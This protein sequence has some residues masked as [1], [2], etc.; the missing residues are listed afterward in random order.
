[1]S[2]QAHPKDAEYLN[3]PIQH[4]KQMQ[5]IFGNGQATGKYAMGSSEPLGTP[6]DFAES[7]MKIDASEDTRGG[8]IEGA[9]A[10]KSEPGVGGKRKRSV[11]SEEDVI[12]FTGMTEAVN[13][14]A[15]AIRETKVEDS[16]PD[17]Y[18]AVMFMPGF[19]DEALL[20]AYGHLLDNKAQG[21]AFVKMNAGHRVLW[22]R[23]FLAKHYYV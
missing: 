10:G 2:L 4:Y 19:T 13:N 17:L 6:S 16:H 15:D 12:L 14:V 23:T 8:K 21:S 5:I 18:D 20:C 7:S 22:L 9:E 11:L 3:K 1:L